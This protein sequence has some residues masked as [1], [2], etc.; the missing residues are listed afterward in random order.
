MRFKY[1]FEILRSRRIFWFCAVTFFSCALPPSS[2]AQ[3]VSASEDGLYTS[4][5]AVQGKKLYASRCAVCHGAD[6]EGTTAPPLAGPRFEKNWISTTTL[7]DL[8]F[9]MRTTMPLSMARSLSAEQHA[10]IFAYILEQNGYPAGSKP[11]Q[12]DTPQLKTMRV[13]SRTANPHAGG[14]PAPVVI[15]GDPKNLPPEPPPSFIPGDAKSLPTSGGPTQEQ[16]NAATRSGRDWLYHTH[17][18]SGA[19]YAPL[20][21]IDSANAKRLQVVCAF[22]VGEIANFQTGPIVY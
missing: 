11:V 8:F 22:Q 17:D 9:L 21:Q 7:D 4:D 5:Q 3:A 19:R 16:L 18:Y 13:Q 14:G 12:P 20:N 2:L 10:A 6:L 1:L 15:P